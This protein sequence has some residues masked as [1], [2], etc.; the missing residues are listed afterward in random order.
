MKEATRDNE[1]PPD[2]ELGRQPQFL[3]LSNCKGMICSLHAV[4]PLK[5]ATSLPGY[6]G[7]LNRFLE[8]QEEAKVAERHR[9]G[10][11]QILLH[12]FN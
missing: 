4:A 10:E 1:Q 6:L 11:L 9:Q 7:P 8:K 5:V 3:H 2:S 12:N